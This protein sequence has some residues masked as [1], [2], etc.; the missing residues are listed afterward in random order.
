M[1]PKGVTGMG[2]ELW[3]CHPT[4]WHGAAPQAV[5]LGAVPGSPWPPRPRAVHVTLEEIGSA[6]GRKS[7]R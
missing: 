2:A 6:R 4:C 1:V 3:F 5:P 7:K